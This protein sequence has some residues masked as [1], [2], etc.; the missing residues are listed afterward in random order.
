MIIDIHNHAN[1]HQHSAEKVIENMDKYGIDVTC[2]LSWEAPKLDYDHTSKKAF[3][4][5][6]DMPVPFERCVSYKENFPDRFLLGFC[7][8]PRE[9]DAIRLYRAA[10]EPGLPRLKKVLQTFP[11]LKFFRSLAPFLV[12]YKRRCYRR[13]SPHLA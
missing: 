2:L 6:S 12:S 11:N 1:Y 9:P 4:P 8:D 5:F 10:G 13:D 7:P 3:S